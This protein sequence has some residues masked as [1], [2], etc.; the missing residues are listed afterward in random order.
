MALRRLS[1]PIDRRQDP[2]AWLALLVLGLLAASRFPALASSPGEIDEAVFAGAVTHYDLFEL[3]PQAPGFPLWILIG[4]ALLPVCIT[5]FNALATASTLLSALAIPA[6]YFWGRRVVG[7]WAALG[8]AAFA[9]ALPVVWVNGG[10]A[11]ADTPGTAFCLAGAALL[12]L[13]EERRVYNLTR[14]REYRLKRRTRLLAVL[15]GLSAAAGFGIRPHLVLGFGLL[16]LVMA[17]RLFS[18]AGRREVAVSFLGALLAGS[19]AWFVWLSAQAG[20]IAGLSASVRE[21]ADFRAH[22]MATGSVGSIPESFAV[23]DFLSLR[24]AA[25]FWLVSAAGVTLLLKRRSRGALD[26]LLVLGPLFVSLWF[27]HNRSMS[28]YS[29]PFALVTSLL[30]GAG[31]EALLR[32]RALGFAAAV[33]AAGFFAR[34]TWPEVL[35]SARETTPPM[36]AIGTLERYVHPGRETI[37]ADG[38]FHAFLRTEIW[39]GRLAAWGY[40][41]DDFV[42]GSVQTNRRLVRLADFTGD[43]DPPCNVDHA[44]RTWVKKGRIA[45]MLGNGRLLDVGLR[46]PAPPL[47]GP[48]FGVTEE[49]AGAPP[50]H[51][52]GPRARLVVP[53]LEGPPVALLSGVRDSE[54]GATTLRVSDAETGD[55]V[56]TRKVEPGPFELAIIPKTIFGPLPRPVTWILSCDRPEPLPR[57]EGAERPRLGC[58]RVLDA[59]FSLPPE[60]IWALSEG[61]Y[62]LDVGPASDRSADP[63]GFHARERLSPS[64]LEM[65]W[66]AGDASVAFSPVEGFVPRRLVVRAR[67]PAAEPVPVRVTVGG[68]SCGEILVQPGD[69]ADYGLDLPEKGKTPFLGE[70]AVRIGLESPT[71]VPRDAGQGEDTR[72]LGIGV[73]RISLE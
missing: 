51:W 53:G 1:G 8:A 37:V 52:A 38:P 16:Y 3:S 46:D 5:P 43:V 17:G 63:D 42:S 10:R 23:R 26:L 32:R 57:L 71:W 20:G 59:T 55:V 29:V 62:V 19:L 24:R 36:A 28:R 2:P 70:A 47:F 13:T 54:A 49:E 15:A 68:F 11:F 58:F 39:E 66:T 4:R 30:F 9:A 44:W 21:R 41:A 35:R 25:V 34:E 27:L 22:A 14:W 73:T 67:A 33:A 72:A 56:L 45:E 12:S 40:T 18:R 69:F 61:R 6:L 7:G 64:G 60:A 50:F 31:L 65:R 48:G